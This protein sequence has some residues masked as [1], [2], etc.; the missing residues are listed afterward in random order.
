M[1]KMSNDLIQNS[2]TLGS[3]VLESGVGNYEM[4]LEEVLGNS[5]SFEIMRFVRKW[6]WENRRAFYVSKL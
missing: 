3:G 4:C 6:Y 2:P 1:P 5:V